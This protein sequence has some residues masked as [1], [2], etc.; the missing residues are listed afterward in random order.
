MG[1]WEACRQAGYE[2]EMAMACD[3]FPAAKKSYVH[4]FKPKQFL[5][6]PIEQ[7]VDGEL[8]APPTEAEV[9]LMEQLGEVN[10]VVGGPPCQG[11]SN[12]NNH[13]RGDDP[14]NELYMRMIRF[15]EL[16]KP[17]ILL[18]ENVRGVV[19]NK[20]KV[21]PRANDYLRKL[22]YRVAHGVVKGEQ[23]GVPQT[24]ARHFTVGLKDSTAEISFDHFSK[25]T[26]SEARS[27]GWAIDDLQGQTAPSEA[28][29]YHTPNAGPV[30]QRRMDYLIDNDIH[31]L[32]NSE[33]P[34][35][36]QGDHT[37]PAVYGRMHWD[38]PSP[39]LTT[40]FGCNGR[41]R[42]THPLEARVLT[43]HEAAR[44]QTFPDFFDLTIIDKRT[45]LHD[46]IGNAV[47]PLMAKHLL[48]RLINLAF[49][50]D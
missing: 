48:S 4:N 39:T 3:L 33:R 41:G 31:D 13:T 10:V 1:L 15:V 5:D 45:D 6:Q 37:Y 28:M 35:C 21:V 18:I 44:V 30:N 38:L 9:A 23:I 24:R 8:G 16:F 34:P 25:P 42:F 29:F 11:N 26:V 7:Y 22:G 12:L 20:Q 36:Q 27:I 49:Q 43:P 40:G 32:P 50:P 17:S 47:P 19:N 46:L 14:R 2:L